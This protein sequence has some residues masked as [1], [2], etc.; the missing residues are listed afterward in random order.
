MAADRPEVLSD[1]TT[2]ALPLSLVLC[3]LGLVASS[4]LLLLLSHHPV[5]EKIIYVILVA[6]IGQRFAKTP[7][8]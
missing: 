2:R 7:G 1:I 4:S 5:T 8:F 3:G 6:M